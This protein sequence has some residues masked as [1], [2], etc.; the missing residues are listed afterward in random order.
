MGAGDA[1]LLISTILFYLGYDTKTTG[2]IS[3]LYA[4]IKIKIVGHEEVI[5]K[6]EFLK[7]LMYILK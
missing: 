2:L 4:S 6:N 3:N 7:S 5:K 1:F